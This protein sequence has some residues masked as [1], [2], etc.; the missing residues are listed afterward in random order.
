MAWDVQSHTKTSQQPPEILNVKAR[1]SYDLNLLTPDT[2]QFYTKSVI[3][4]AL[5]AE[6]K[7]RKNDDDDDDDDEDDEDEDDNDNNTY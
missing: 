7:Q 3:P 6:T 1:T 2:P 4:L 5:A